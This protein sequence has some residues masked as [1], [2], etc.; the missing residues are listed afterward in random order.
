MQKEQS[1]I[2]WILDRIE[3][4]FSNKYYKKR[5]IR[6]N[7]I[8]ALYLCDQCNTVWSIGKESYFRIAHYYQDLP[9]YGKDKKKCPHC[10]QKNGVSK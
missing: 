4:G 2:E 6:K 5:Y 9:K 10:A 3:E 1:T 7:T 8:E